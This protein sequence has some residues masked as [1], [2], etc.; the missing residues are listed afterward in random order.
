MKISK[1]MIKQ[2]KKNFTHRS[3]DSFKELPFY[4]DLMKQINNEYSNDE[5]EALQWIL[6]ELGRNVEYET[7]K[8]R[9][10][11]DYKIDI[12]LTKDER[13]N[14][15]QIRV[16]KILYLLLN[17]GTHKYMGH[18]LCSNGGYK[19][20]PFYMKKKDTI[21]EIYK[22]FD[23]IANEFNIINRNEAIAKIQRLT[24][25]SKKELESD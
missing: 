2:A 13:R 15:I 9:L 4:K 25:C 14:N 18:Q 10:S 1:E 11:I 19:L 12:D 24:K 7:I 16:F 3:S 23:K 5:I 17:D 8:N 6:Q 20:I 21:K 22:A